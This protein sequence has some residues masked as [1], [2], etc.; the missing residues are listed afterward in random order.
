MSSPS[1]THALI[2]GPQEVTKQYR[3]WDKGQPEREWRALQ[4]LATYAPGL[5]PAPL[6]ANLDADAPTAVPTVVMSRLPG[7]PLGQEPVTPQ[8]LAAMATAITTLQSAIPAQV[9]AELPPRLGD[10]TSMLTEVRTWY[11]SG[12]ELGADPL[13]AKAFAS[14]ADWLFDNSLE[15]LAHAPVG[16]VLGSGDGNLGNIIW[17]ADMRR[18]RLVDYEYSGRSDRAYELAEIAEHISMWVR[19]AVD[20]SSLLELFDLSAAEQR[21]LKEFR[22]LFA[23]FWFLMLLPKSPAHPRNPAGTLQHQAE[24]LLTLMG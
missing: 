12:P 24:R 3:S 4:L 15:A 20:P 22:R 14:G 8:Q 1:T 9:L 13:V 19:G 23:F 18:V 10:P 16:A 17:D 11:A 6:R 21:R 7:A 5:A 2:L